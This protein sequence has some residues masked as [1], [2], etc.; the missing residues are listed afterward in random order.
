[1]G[2]IVAERLVESGISVPM[3]AVSAGRADEGTTETPREK[4]AGLLRNQLCL[5]CP[6]C[7]NDCDFIDLYKRN[8]PDALQ[9]GVKPCGGFLFL[10]RLLDMKII[11]IR[12]INQVI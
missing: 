1:M 3:A 2:F 12:D 7:E 8:S 6:F 5:V 4:T 10:G 9:T 11:D